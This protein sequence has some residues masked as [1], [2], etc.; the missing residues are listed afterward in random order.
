M[1]QGLRID[2]NTKGLVQF[3]CH[4]APCRIQLV[5]AAGVAHRVR[6]TH[7]ADSMEGDVIF[8]MNKRMFFQSVRLKSEPRSGYNQLKMHFSV[9]IILH[10]QK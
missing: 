7:P 2:V 1:C 8:L 4:D 6:S 3:C 5:F 10:W 9:C